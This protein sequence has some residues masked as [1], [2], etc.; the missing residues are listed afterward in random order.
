MAQFMIVTQLNVIKCRIKWHTSMHKVWGPQNIIIIMQ[1][2]INLPHRLHK[3][4]NGVLNETLC[5]LFSSLKSTKTFRKLSAKAFHFSVF[6]SFSLCYSLIWKSVHGGGQG[7]RSR[8]C[9]SEDIREN[10]RLW[11]QWVWPDTLHCFIR[12]SYMAERASKL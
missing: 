11:C 12:R 3:T 7:V 6:I 1:I 10:D 5:F 8:K 4:V 9:L 2:F